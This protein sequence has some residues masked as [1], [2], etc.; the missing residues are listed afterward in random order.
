MKLVNILIFALIFQGCSSFGDSQKGTVS[1]PTK[2]NLPISGK[3][4]EYIITPEKDN[5]VDSAIA[6]N[7][8]KFEKLAA[9]DYQPAGLDDYLF[10][11]IL[12]IVIDGQNR[13]YILDETR[14]EVSV[15]NQRGEYLTTLGRLGKG[16]GEFE[17]ARSMTLYKDEMLLVNSGYE[18]EI[19]DISKPEIEFKSTLQLE[20]ASRSMCSIDDTLF[21]HY[22]GLHLQKKEF[23]KEGK[24]SMIK[25]YSLPE[26]EPLFSFGESYK[27]NNIMIVDR[28]S[29]GEISCNETTSTVVFG[30]ERFP[31]LHGYSMQGELKW[32]TYISGLKT[33]ILE[34]SKESNRTKISYKQPKGKFV[35]RIL[36]SRSLNNKYQLSQ[37]DRILISDASFENK[38]EEISFMI[39]SETGKGEMVS[40]D[41]PLIFGIS[42]GS[43]ISIDEIFTEANIRHIPE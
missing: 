11:F 32:K 35:D 15:F 31:V 28:L 41:I 29:L 9:A 16:P 14:Q 19:F 27:S 13:I 43:V 12:D 30:F 33:T 1:H 24:L 22:A 34:T 4:H 23:G 26:F 7:A 20:Y 2:I 40:T 18:I 8:H 38:R 39:D 17:H 42:D 36:K 5:P 21:V 6:S 3:E 10:G 37:I 25:A